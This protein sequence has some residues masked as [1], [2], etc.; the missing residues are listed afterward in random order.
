MSKLCPEQARP[1]PATQFLRFERNPASRSG[2]LFG[3]LFHGFPPIPNLL[4]LPDTCQAIANI[5]NHQETTMLATQLANYIIILDDAAA[6]SRKI[7]DKPLYQKYLAHAGL[8]LALA[9]LNK[10]KQRLIDAIDAHENLWV[11]SWLVDDAYQKP[12]EAWRDLADAWMAIKTN[13]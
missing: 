5:R 2:D 13:L 1:Q 4:R 12:A 3:S 7:D 11:H 9:V 10:D 8:M 6:V